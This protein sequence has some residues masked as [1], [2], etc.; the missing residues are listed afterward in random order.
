MTQADLAARLEV[1]QSAVARL[2]SPRSNPR[3]GTLER[4]LAA[5]GHALKVELEPVG[6]PAIDESLLVSMLRLPPAKRLDY[7]VGSYRELRRLAPTV[8][9]DGGPEG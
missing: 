2:E 4:T 3:L 5:T 6:Y 8:G 9:T 1:S 7:F